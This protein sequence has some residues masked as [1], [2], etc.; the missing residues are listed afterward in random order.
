MGV[1][2]AKCTHINWKL[3]TS[4]ESF[5]SGKSRECCF[6]ELAV[7]RRQETAQ[8]L[9]G[10][11]KCGEGGNNTS[12]RRKIV[13]IRLG[14]EKGEAKRESEEVCFWLLEKAGINK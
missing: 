3:S 12:H 14:K 6:L 5:C 7:Q 2:F 11:Q 10:E 8:L 1:L 4:S 13:S 9:P